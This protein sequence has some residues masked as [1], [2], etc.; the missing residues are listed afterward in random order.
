MDALCYRFGGQKNPLKELTEYK[1]EGEL[2][3]YIKDFDI[4]WNKAKI[5]KRQALVFFLGGV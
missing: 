3:G 2:E 5:S 1:Q 4:L